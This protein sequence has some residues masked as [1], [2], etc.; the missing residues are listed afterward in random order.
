MKP[1]TIVY[2]FIGAFACVA[3]SSITY[4]DVRGTPYK[5]GY[6]IEQLQ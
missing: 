3:T 1:S 2:I 6:D 5:V 4:N